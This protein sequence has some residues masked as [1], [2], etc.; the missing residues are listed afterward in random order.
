[1]AEL[2]LDEFRT[3]PHPLIGHVNDGTEGIYVGRMR[4]STGQFNP[5]GNPFR[6]GEDGTREEVIEKFRVWL[7]E[8]CSKHRHVWIPM[9]AA[10]YQE[11]LICHCFPLPCHA[12]ILIEAAEWAWFQIGGEEFPA[13]DVAKEEGVSLE[14]VILDPDGAVWIAAQ[15][16]GWWEDSDELF[17]EPWIIAE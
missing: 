7:R 9:L 6:V 13:P 1:M 14:K 11:R 12:E 16:D 10:L 3:E 8:Q 2:P 17:G 4:R 5:L 15:V